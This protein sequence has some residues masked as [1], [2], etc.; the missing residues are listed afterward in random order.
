[1]KT[2]KA[3]KMKKVELAKAENGVV[4]FQLVEFVIN[5]FGSEVVTV[6]DTKIM[7]DGRQFV[8]GGCGYI[9]DGFEVAA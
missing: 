1:M 4:A 7:K 3:N 5:F 6:H 9:A 8:I 2:I